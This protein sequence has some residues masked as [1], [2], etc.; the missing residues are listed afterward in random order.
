MALL[1]ELS[2]ASPL[3][4]EFTLLPL[5]QASG[6]YERPSGRQLHYAVHA[7]CFWRIFCPTLLPSDKSLQTM[8]GASSSVPFHSASLYVGDL[9]TDASEVRPLYLYLQKHVRAGTPLRNIQYSRS[10]C[11][12]PRM[13]R[14]RDA[15]EPRLC[16]CQ[17]PQRL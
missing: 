10:S 14:C 7:A 3:R 6:R 5:A 4:E 12:D 11:F 2:S 13:S 17:L 9:A 16:L 1:T 15:T 8:L